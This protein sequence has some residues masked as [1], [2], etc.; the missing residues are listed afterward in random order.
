M[1][2][3]E[4]GFYALGFLTCLALIAVIEEVN[5]KDKKAKR[6]LRKRHRKAL[7]EQK[8]DTNFGHCGWRCVS[9]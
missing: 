1:F 6:E 5:D 8:I 7:A 2:G 4:V 3:I 9:N